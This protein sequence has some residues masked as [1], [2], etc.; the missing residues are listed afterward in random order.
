MEEKTSQE[1]YYKNSTSPE[2]LE[3]TAVMNS[4]TEEE[5][6]F[7][8]ERTPVQ[9]FKKGTI[10]LREGEI[11]NKSYFP[12][13]G[14]VRQYYLID[15]IEKTTFFFTEGQSISSFQ[16][17]NEKTPSKYYLE[18][19]EDCRLTVSFHEDELEMYRRFPKF[20]M[21]CLKE[22]ERQLGNYQE[23]LAYYITSSPEE[24]YLNLLKTRSELLNRV[25]QHQIASY[26]G[27]K[28]ESLSRIRKRISLK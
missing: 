9:F 2:F 24:R 20:K 8:R 26:L 7:I 15:G 25:P 5:R 22:T 21:L 4:L 12:F 6:A 11:A 13:E 1:Y 19:V 27:V 28:P 17:I 18:C 23:M 3:Y 16:G 10:L 14:C